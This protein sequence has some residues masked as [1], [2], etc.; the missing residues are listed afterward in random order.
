MIKGLIFDFDGLILDTEGPEYQAWQEIFTSHGCTLPLSEWTKCLGSS[1]DAFDPVVYLGSLVNGP[2]EGDE[3]RKQYKARSHDLIRSK[4]LLPGVKEYI[5]T[6]KDLGLKLAIASSSTYEWVTGHLD[7]FCLTDQFDAIY[8]QESVV[9]VK[10][11]PYLFQNALNALGISSNQAIVFEDS[12]NG[13]I[14]ANAAGIYCVAVP[15]QISIT[16][17][18]S[19]AD[20]ILSSLADLPLRE[21]LRTV[22]GKGEDFTK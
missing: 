4:S 13:V 2:V 19:S 14:A 17:D 22:N 7:R 3:L 10:P 16:L 5:T 12:L 9:K 18:L 1:T 20:L 11:A 21:L 8:T 6:A 15:N